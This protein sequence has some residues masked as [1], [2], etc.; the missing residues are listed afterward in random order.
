M[1]IFVCLCIFLYFF[2][3]RLHF[4]LFVLG[5]LS[6]VADIAPKLYWE[7]TLELLIF[8]LEIWDTMTKF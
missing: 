3:T 8:A 1:V 6:N 7:A 5:Q 4:F 2:V